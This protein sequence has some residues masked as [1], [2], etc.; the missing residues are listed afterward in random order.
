MKFN[1]TEVRKAIAT[2]KPD[3]GVFEIRI[4]G[5][6]KKMWSGFFLD[7]DTCVDRMN[8]LYINENCNVYITLQELVESCDSRSQRD[9]FLPNPKTTSDDDVKGYDWLFI[10]ID[11][12]RAADTSS[13]NAELE[14]ANMVAHKVFDFFKSF[15]FEE[16]VVAF[17]GNGI[18]LQ[19][20][21]NL[22]N[23]PDNKGLMQRCLK[24]VAMMFNDSVA[25]IDVVNYNPARVC[26]LYGTEAQ[27]GIST[28][29]R[30]HRMSY[31]M[32]CPRIVK[33]TSK[34]YLEKLANLL[35]NKV[36]REPYNNFNP[37]TFNL[38]EWLSNH[39]IH[40]RTE[41]GGDSTRYVLDCCPFNSDHK[42]KN[43]MI[44][45]SSGG[46]IGFH[47]F[48]NSCADKTW[49]DVRELFEPDAYRRKE[50]ERMA[51][52]SYNRNSSP[53]PM[54]V[55]CD[56]ATVP[57]AN[58]PMFLTRSDVLKKPKMKKTYVKTGI[59]EMDMK[60]R[61]LRKGAVS[62]WSGLNGSAKSTLLSQIALNAIDD[63]N[64]VLCYSG[65]L[66]DRNFFD[67]MDLQAAGKK[68]T[69]SYE[70]NNYYEPMQGVVEKIANWESNKLWLYNNNYG[71]DY[72][73]IRDEIIK[74]IDE[75]KIDLLILD[76]LMALNIAVFSE[77]KYG[78]QTKFILD[79][80]SI[81]KTKNVHIAIVAHPRK[82]MGFLRRE[83]ISGSA[84]LSNAVDYVFIVHRN[85]K[86]FKAR[87]CHDKF[88]NNA[89]KEDDRIFT[90]E[91][92]NVVEICKDRDGGVQDTF[93]PLWFEIESKR[94]KN[95]KSETHCYGWETDGTAQKALANGGW[96]TT[97]E[98]F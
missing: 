11:P 74:K 76:N 60:L 65:E 6:S 55:L 21:I 61:G 14:H 79:L 91:A 84:D 10:D 45:K 64:I 88:G 44:F 30:P 80:C 87:A 83:D 31:I 73:K 69:I 20:R 47:C 27:K 93:I 24:A 63:G 29:D 5:A 77:E 9:K 54:P 32:S 67:W 53:K 66:T 46:A 40:Y 90:E 39:G 16:P 1:E 85:N 94:L 33:T 97:E 72:Q 15:G 37:T 92:T 89:L 3:G 59:I 51:Y 42:G 86:D 23:N 4:V 96:I 22:E 82:S 26:K 62:L 56:V 13:N 48:H 49:K 58:E 19:Y 71:N 41:N 35:P 78:A 34:A 36:E 81:A 95:D 70:N 25:K 98:D 17:S 43:A 8:N 7:A 75:C 68:N 52:H 28:C 38:D 18:H 50:Y 12:K 2:I 57:P